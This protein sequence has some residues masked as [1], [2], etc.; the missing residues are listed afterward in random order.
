MKHLHLAALVLLT[1]CASYNVK[2]DAVGEGQ[3]QRYFMV[4]RPETDPARGPWTRL[5]TYIER[6]LKERGFER[7][8]S[9]PLE[10]VFDFTWKDTSY[11]WNQTLTH[12]PP[13]VVST[14]TGTT[15][16]RYGASQDVDLEVS[17]PSA[18]VHQITTHKESRFAHSLTVTAKLVETGKEAWSVKMSVENDENKPSKTVPAMLAGGLGA[19]GTTHQGEVKVTDKDPKYKTIRGAE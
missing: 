1:S 7:A 10:V 2:V 6:A 3:A 16:S 8:E 14:V 4:H 5:A 11:T 12:T 18:P 17:T 19:I 15:K 9:A 13:P